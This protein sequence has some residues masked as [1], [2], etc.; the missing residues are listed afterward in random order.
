MAIIYGLGEVIGE[1]AIEGEVSGF[2]AT[3]RSVGFTN[4]SAYAFM[5]FTL[6][7]TPCVAAIGVI[8]RETNSWKWTGFSLA[9][10]LIVAWGGA[11]IVYQVG[12]LLFG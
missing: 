6:L 1:A 4:I 8:K 12:T 2:S 11:F 9:Y 5:V 10:Q 7:Y 3:L